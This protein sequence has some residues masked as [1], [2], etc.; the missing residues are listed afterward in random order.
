MYIP[1]SPLMLISAFVFGLLSSFLAYKR[2]RNPYLWFFLGFLFGI[3]GIFAIFFA[4]GEKKRAP[5]SERKGEPVFSIHGP[6]DKFWYYLDP[7]HQQQG[8]MS[9]DALNN[10]WKEGKIDSSTYVW[11]EEMTEWKPLKE[12]IKADHELMEKL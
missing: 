11:N 4:T 12:M 1:I 8:P 9:R 7:S 5:H 2:G 3:F 10:A 6:L